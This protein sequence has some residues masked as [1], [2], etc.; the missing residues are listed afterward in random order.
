MGTIGR[1][2]GFLL[3]LA[4]LFVVALAAGSRWGPTVTAPVG[5][6]D[7]PGHEATAGHAAGEAARLPG[8][9]MRSQDGYSLDLGQPTAEPGDDVPLSF[10]VTGPDGAPVR[11]YA[12]EH[13]RRLHLIVVRR[14]LTGYQHVH[15]RLGEDGTW[16]TAVDL[17]PGTWRVFADFTA[18]DG[19]ALTL[20]T[21]LTVPGRVPDVPPVGDDLRTS[22][23]DGY[24]V[25]LDG[26]LDG[27]AASDLTLTVTRDGR[28]VTDLQPYL[29]AFGHLVAL[30]EGD[31]AYLHVHPHSDDTAASS[32]SLGG[33]ELDFT[34]EVPSAGRYRLFLDFKADGVVRTATFD[35]EAG[36]DHGHD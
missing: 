36:G 30:R 32:S 17:E 6:A 5:H 28:P 29:G 31:L 19:P 27:G 7:E 12:V 16:S 26:D 10:T 25:A 9:L 14:D 20:G 33:P 21:D 18:T 3:G 1:V 2:A 35:L 24:D 8:G 22:S 13:G 11:S 34:A 15:P 23:V 4:V